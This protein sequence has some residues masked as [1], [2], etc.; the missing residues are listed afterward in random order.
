MPDAELFFL[1]GA[2]SLAELHTWR[3]PE[4]ICQLAFVAIIARAD[5]HFPTYYSLC[6]FCLPLSMRH[7]RVT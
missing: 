6:V 7:S 5:S 3:D 1:M 4:A 2:D